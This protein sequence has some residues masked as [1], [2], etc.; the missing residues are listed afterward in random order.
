MALL[1]WYTKFVDLLDL[2]RVQPI[3]RVIQ[4]DFQEATL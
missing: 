1:W 4:F 2:L 3:K